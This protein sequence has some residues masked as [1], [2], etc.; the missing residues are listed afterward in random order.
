LVIRSLHSSCHSNPQHRLPRS[1]L[2]RRSHHHHS[3]RPSSRRC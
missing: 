3:H 1:S 2:S